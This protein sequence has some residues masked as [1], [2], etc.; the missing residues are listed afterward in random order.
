MQLK[1]QNMA[2]QAAVVLQQHQ[3]PGLVG[4]L[5]SVVAVVDQVVVGQ[6]RLLQ[7]YLLLEVIV[8][9]S[10]QVVVVLLD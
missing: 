10:Q 7:H 5:Y 4:V 8:V 6:P 3:Q 1:V 9:Y 2:E